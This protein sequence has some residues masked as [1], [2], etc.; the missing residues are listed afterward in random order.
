MEV[1]GIGKERRKGGRGEGERE[2]RRVA[3]S[4]EERGSMERRVRGRADRSGG[5]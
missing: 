5:G 4:V 1:L 3:A 2:D